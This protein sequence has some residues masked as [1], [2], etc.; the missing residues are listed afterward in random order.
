MYNK[1]V[2]VGDNLL[3]RDF[4]PYRIIFMNVPVVTTVAM[5]ILLR[6]FGPYG[7]IFMSVCVYH[8]ITFSRHF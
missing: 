5:V 6:D 7:I 2:L 1:Q 8:F 3:L 4:G